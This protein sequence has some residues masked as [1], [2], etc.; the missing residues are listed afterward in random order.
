MSEAGIRL[1]LLGPLEARVGDRAV[2]IPH[3]RPAT[4]L[5]LLALSAG[6][7]VPADTLADGV[8]GDRPPQRIRPSLAS[9]VLRLRQ[10]LDPDAIRTTT[11]GY[12]LDLAPDAVDALRFR[13]L[14]RQAAGAPPA[15]AEALLDEA[16]GLWRGEP[17]AG[18]RS[19]LLDRELAALAE[20]RLVARSERLGLD[21][22]A[23]RYA[24]AVEP[25]AELIAA[26]PLREPLW[27]QLITALAGAGRG[28]EA[29]AAYERLR[30]R[31]RDELGADPSAPL[32]ALHQQLLTGPHSGADAAAGRPPA[33]RPRGPAPE[34]FPVRA[35]APDPELVVPG[36]SRRRPAQLPGDVAGYTG[37][38][39]ELRRLD[40]LLG[41][42]RPAGAAVVAIT[43]SA[44]VGKTALAVHWAHRSAARFTDGVLYLN[45]NGYAAGRPVR[46]IDALHR[47]LRT[48][49][50]AGDQL[51]S[52][53]DEAAAL[54]RTLLS[55]SAT[56]VVLDNAAHP[57]Q[58]R[59]LLPGS[60]VGAVLVTSRD[61]LSGLVAVDG[62]HR[63]ALDVLAPGDAVE[64]LSRLV[65]P[66]AVQ[67]EVD[68]VGDLAR[69]CGYLPLALR[70]AA[71]NLT[72]HP[73]QTL[74]EY[75][76]G[77]A[78]GRLA[79]L[80]VDGDDAAAVRAAFDRSYAVLADPARR[81]FRLLGLVPGSDV[82]AA[83]AD[84]VSGHS[85]PPAAGVLSQLAAAHLLEQHAPGRYTFHDLL[86]LYAA[87]R[88]DAEVSAEDR[89][90]A[91][92]RL[93]RHYLAGVLAAG[94]RLYPTTSRLPAPED[95]VLP[96]FPTTA[97]ALSWLDT[98]RPNVVAAVRHAAAHGP[99]ET[100]WLLADGLRMYL[101]LR[102]HTTDWEV[103][104][105]AGMVAADAA[106][107]PAPRAAMR[108]SLALLRARQSRM[109]E[110]IDLGET[111]G[112]LA[113]A[114]GWLVGEAS[115]ANNLG[116]CYA[117]TGRNRRA[118][119]CF[120]RALA[121]NRRL[122]RVAGQAAA[123]TNLGSLYAEFGELE[124]SAEHHREALAGHRA[125][126]NRVGEATVLSEYGAACHALGRLAEANG[127]L[128]QALELARELGNQVTEAETMHRLALVRRDRGALGAAYDLAREALE[129][130]T[131]MHHRGIIGWSALA[132]GA[133]EGD[134][135]EHAATAAHC[136]QAL[137]TAGSI[138]DGYLRAAALAGL[139]AARLRLG[140][141]EAALADATA[142]VR[143][144]RAGGYQLVEAQ[145]VTVLA[146]IRLCQ[147]ELDAGAAAA[148][149]AAGIHG[150]A[151]HLLG[152]ARARV[153]LA[154]ALHRAGQRGPAAREWAEATAA[155]TAAGAALTSV[156][157]LP[158]TA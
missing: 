151:G 56:L 62:A 128:E 148:R 135:G 81:H 116:L 150:R 22:A 20:E 102:L 64:L 140:G 27:H 39:A 95:L 53:V 29:L 91:L 61:R 26:H 33:G 44:G 132:L 47:F 143:F 58:V 70:I 99:A 60:A 48:L 28:A 112:R 19:D 87:E 14:V 8:W 155:F 31:L 141:T 133:I 129:L 124:R 153:L 15:R 51:P 45:L 35:N 130:A 146:A 131:S 125:V 115:A 25:L 103:V 114:A 40:Q 49:G 18:I 54:Y 34:P 24:A 137:E 94:D 126:G 118:A 16:L 139:A 104:A 142:A 63:L 75:T 107:D 83:A 12:A 17:L 84:A 37:R 79:A 97:A 113:H 21:L 156:E 36:R 93:G 32:R 57:D 10:M 120:R 106:G 66:A 65:G 4:V 86:R 80:Q 123:L 72:E 122:G 5:A 9:L 41:P 108:I 105:R 90:D 158:R 52:D 152:Q 127:Y 157:E 111:A 89:A 11:A 100:A 88:A 2:A 68:A 119:A 134:R 147:G 46:P 67:S 73:H 98:E 3:G 78:G 85:G 74:A 23:G 138:A 6:R 136:E 121:L 71:A 38:S 101:Y 13:S 144:A 50:V 145:A 82:D 76:T 43:G 110:A 59:P 69:H 154:H 30:V 117:N 96:D 1:R 7:S 42:G 77:L 149:E 109:D 92:A 55:G